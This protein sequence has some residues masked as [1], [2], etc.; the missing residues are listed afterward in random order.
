MRSENTMTVAE[1]IEALRGFPAEAEV[2]IY[3]SEVNKPLRLCLGYVNSVETINHDTVVISDSG[4]WSAVYKDETLAG[5]IA[6]PD[7]DDRDTSGLFED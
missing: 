5:Q 3:D 7:F 6:I 1:L 4:F 2:Y